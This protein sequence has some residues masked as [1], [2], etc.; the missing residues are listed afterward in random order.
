VP[1]SGKPHQPPLLFLGLLLLGW[2]LGFLQP[3]ELPWPSSAR[4]ALGGTLALLA[5]GLGAWGVATF[6]RKGTSPDPNGT[7]TVLLTSGPFQFSRNPLY[8][9]LA[10]LLASFGLGLDSGW[11]LLL[12]PVLVLLL[13]RLVIALEEARLQA[14]FG[15]AYLAYTKRVRRWL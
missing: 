9:A 1:R 8:L 3:L 5:A 6:R 15:A 10:L 7:A 4:Y 14:Q 13:D 12:V 2:G 11:I